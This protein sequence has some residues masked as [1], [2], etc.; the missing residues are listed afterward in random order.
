MPFFLFVPIDPKNKGND[1]QKRLELATFAA[2]CFWGIESLFR[3]VKGVRDVMVGYTGGSYPYPSYEDVCTKTTGHAEAVLVFFDPSEVSYRDL[4]NIFWGNHD[5]TQLNRQGPDVGDQ[6]RSAIFFHSLEQRE[7]AFE[8]KR[9]LE[10]QASL[11]SAIVTQ[12]VPAEFFYRAEE[13][14][15]RY[16]EKH[17]GG[18]CHPR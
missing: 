6:Y 10:S 17:G 18:T 4:L 13:Y 12:I 7:I 3:P 1:P 14:H 2:G 5:P 15:Q 16:F 11:S 9:L 8:A